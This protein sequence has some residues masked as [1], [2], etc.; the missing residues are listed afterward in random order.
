MFLVNGIATMSTSQTATVVV[1]AEQRTVYFQDMNDG[2]AITTTICR[3]N[4]T[5]AELLPSQ[6][7]KVPETRYPARR[8]AHSLVD[9][10]INY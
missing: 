2:K 6:T 5:T 8:V 1:N 9:Q 7:S 10:I 4:E 3:I